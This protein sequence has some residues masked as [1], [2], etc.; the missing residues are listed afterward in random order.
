M[1]DCYSYNLEGRRCQR[2]AGHDEGEPHLFEITWTDE[3]AWSPDKGPLPTEVPSV[4]PPRALSAV[5]DPDLDIPDPDADEDDAF[6]ARVAAAARKQLEELGAVPTTDPVNPAA[7]VDPATGL[8]MRCFSCKHPWHED[9]CEVMMG[10]GKQRV[11]CGCSIAV[12]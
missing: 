9:E 11:E 10:K 12:S 8:P 6:E 3:E 4:A 5:P 1:A 2:A 7:P